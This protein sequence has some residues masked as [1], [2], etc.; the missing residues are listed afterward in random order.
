MTNKQKVIT[1]QT[2]FEG[3]PYVQLTFM[4]HGAKK[5]RTVWAIQEGRIAFRRADPEGGVWQKDDGKVVTEELI[6]VLPD[7][8]KLKPA[9]V[10]LHYGQLEVLKDA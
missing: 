1:H 10:S 4:P 6:I 5:L 7:E 2:H 9:G 3:N 8:Q